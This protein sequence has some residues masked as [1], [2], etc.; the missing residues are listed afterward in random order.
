MAAAC[1]RQP[2]LFCN[3]LGQLQGRILSG[4]SRT[5][6]SAP[7]SADAAAPGPRARVGTMRGWWKYGWKPHRDLLAQKQQSWAS[8]GWYMRKTQ[9]G[10]VSSNSRCQQYY[11]NSVPPTPQ[12][13]TCTAAGFVPP[14]LRSIATPTPNTP[15]WSILRFTLS[16]I[17]LIR[18]TLCVWYGYYDHV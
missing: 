13:I 10:T 5:A 9:M 8:C 11:F 4:T 16:R 12:T 18:S 7:S 1:S 17:A 15:F 3:Q 2:S 6:R 14:R